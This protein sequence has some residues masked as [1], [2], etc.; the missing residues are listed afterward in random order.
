MYKYQTE[1]YELFFDFECSAR[2]KTLNYLCFSLG[3]IYQLLI[4]N[5]IT[6]VRQMNGYSWHGS[7]LRVEVAKE[8]FL[9]RLKRERME[10]QQQD[11]SDHSSVS[12]SN[13][14]NG[15]ENRRKFDFNQGMNAKKFDQNNSWENFNRDKRREKPS[16]NGYMKY[17]DSS[18]ARS[19]P[20]KSNATEETMMT[21]F[22]KYS[23]VWNDSEEEDSGYGKD[24]KPRNKMV[25]KT[26]CFEYVT[27]LD[28]A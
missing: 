12:M 4:K 23:S 15:E 26:H 28:I 5:L 21:S 22:K 3:C 20:K 1:S 11:R 25:R 2:H 18:G 24:R 27:I 16:D 8:S 10:A 13:W 6:G 9:D 19:Q 7:Q 17:G 14:N